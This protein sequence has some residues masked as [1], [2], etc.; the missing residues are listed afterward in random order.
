LFLLRLSLPI[1]RG[2]TRQ[3]GVIHG[4]EQAT[5]AKEQ[6]QDSQRNHPNGSASLRPVH[7]RKLFLLLTEGFVEV[8]FT[9][10]HHPSAT[11]QGPV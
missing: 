6:G 8:V 11:Q 1:R 9:H 2:S 10:R 3:P 4:E 5:E 7:L